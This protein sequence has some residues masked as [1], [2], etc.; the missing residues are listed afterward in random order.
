MQR[1]SRTGRWTDGFTL[2][3]MLVVLAISAL[4]ATG[5][6]LAWPGLSARLELDR[7]ERTIVGMLA[8]AR[9]SALL[10]HGPVEVEFDR[11]G[12]RF[13]VSDG[14]SVPIPPEVGVTVTGV[15]ALGR[16]GRP[17]IVFLGDGSSSGAI[18]TLRGGEASRVVVVS[19]LTGRIRHGT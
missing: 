19:W 12:P 8:E 9:R 11:T 2:L 17:R 18:V 15:A 1:T 16:T 13:E 3:E 14:R 7:T 6:G 5:A 10:A 4:V